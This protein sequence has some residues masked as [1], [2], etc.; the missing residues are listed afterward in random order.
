MRALLCKPCCKE[1]NYH[2]V[3]GDQYWYYVPCLTLAVEIV[4]VTVK[5]TDVCKQ[6]FKSCVQYSKEVCP[7]RSDLALYFSSYTPSRRFFC[8]FSLHDFCLGFWHDVAVI[9]LASTMF[10]CLQN[11][12]ELCYV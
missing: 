11:G 7:L 2:C 10:L 12:L 5:L 1:N 4:L 6:D 8:I 3:G 9:P